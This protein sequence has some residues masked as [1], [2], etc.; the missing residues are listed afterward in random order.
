MSSHRATYWCTECEKFIA[1][2]LH[3]GH[4]LYHRQQ[5]AKKDRPIDDPVGN[6][7]VRAQKPYAT[8]RGRETHTKGGPADV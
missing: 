4:A 3:K 8:E 5:A 1:V 6:S 7:E 2:V